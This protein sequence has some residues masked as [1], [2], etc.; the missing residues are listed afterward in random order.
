LIWLTIKRAIQSLERQKQI[1]SE[2]VE[3]EEALNAISLWKGALLPP[4]RAGS[5]TSPY[6]PLVYQEF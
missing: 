5:Y 6:L 2:S 3:S 1:P 4:D